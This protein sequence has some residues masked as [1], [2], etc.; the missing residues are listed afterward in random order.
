[1]HVTKQYFLLIILIITTLSACRQDIDVMEIETDQP[2]PEILIRTAIQ[3][4]VLDESSKAVPDISVQTGFGETTTDEN[5]QFKFEQALVS[6]NA[7]VAKVD[8]PDYF[9]GAAGANFFADGSSYLEINVLS[10][11]DPVV[12]DAN[13]TSEIT[14]DG[15][16]KVSWEAG[17]LT[18]LSGETLEG[19]QNLF[20]KSLNPNDPDFIKNIPGSLVTFDE[21]GNASALNAKAALALSFESQAALPLSFKEDALV[22]LSIPVGDNSSVD[23]DNLELFVFDPESGQWSSA[24]PCEIESGFY[25]YS[26]SGFCSGNCWLV[27]CEPFPAICLSATIVNEDGSPGCFLQVL[28]EDQ[29]EG[30]SYWGFTDE[31][32]KFCGSV[33]T[34]VSMTFTVVDQC[35]N[36]VYS[37]V[38]GPFSVDTNLG[39][40][41]L[42][43]SVD[44][45]LLNVNGTAEHCDQEAFTQGHLVLYMP[46]GTTVISSLISDEINLTGPLKCVDFPNIEIGVY[47]ADQNLYS[48]PL[49]FNGLTDIDLGTVQ[50]CSPYDDYMI[51]DIDGDQYE[52]APTQWVESGLDGSG[53][54]IGSGSTS[55]SSFDL[56][57]P[58][59]QGPGSYSTDVH[60]FTT[61]LDANNG[62]QYSEPINTNNQIVNVIIT[63]DDGNYVEGSLNGMGTDPN[64]NLVPVS[65][66]FKFRIV[67]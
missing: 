31:F 60:F 26:G 41:V 49:L 1:M 52:F 51:A 14:A 44:S 35:S 32:G 16:S 53:F 34:G 22:E 28:V 15:G 9:L 64:N 27:V 20:S 46:G 50:L 59:Y 33:P 57:I 47:S 63:S 67:Q 24:G 36:E 40:V 43:D 13:Q 56:Q 18:A 61:F 66:T 39:N 42:S 55:N 54:Y 25:T 5:G 6:Q 37:E 48:G 29:I 17:A 21:D 2:A 10:K 45:F 3:G 12:F 30:F 58:D 38:V 11:G 7:G 8:N 23:S 19:A 62:G 4:I 65:A